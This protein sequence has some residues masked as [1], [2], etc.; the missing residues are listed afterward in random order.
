MAGTREGTRHHGREGSDIVRQDWPGTSWHDCG[1]ERADDQT[2]ARPDE[3]NAKSRSTRTRQADGVVNWF[4]SNPIGN[5]IGNDLVDA[6]TRLNGYV[7]SI[8]GKLTPKSAIDALNKARDQRLSANYTGGYETHPEQPNPAAG[9]KKSPFDTAGLGKPQKDIFGDEVRKL[10]LA[11]AQQKAYLA[12]WTALRSRSMPSP[13]Q[14]RRAPS[15][16]S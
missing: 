13:R 16:W 6:N 5:Y 7:S 12:C 1:G 10:D 15:S 8:L 2:K 4:R 3:L 14:R 11:I 9:P